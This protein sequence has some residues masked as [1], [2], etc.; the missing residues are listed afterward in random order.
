M[1]SIKEARKLGEYAPKAIALVKE[2]AIKMLE[3]GTK[4]YAKNIITGAAVGAAALLGLQ[5]LNKGKKE[6][7]VELEANKEGKIQEHS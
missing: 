2:D 7:G 6:E 1:K 5:L 3:K 4:N